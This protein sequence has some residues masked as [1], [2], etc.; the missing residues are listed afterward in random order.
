MNVLILVDIQNDFVPGG[1]L[2][3]EGGDQVVAVANELM[4]KFDLVIATQDWHPADH[5]S[6]ASQHE[7]RNVG[8]VID[9]DGLDQILWP[10]HCVQGTFGAEFVETLN[11]DG[12]DHVFTKGTQRQIDSY[13]GFFD[14]GRRHATGLGDFLKD[15]S[16]QLVSIMGLATDYCVKFTALDAA[17]LGFE[18][19]LIVAGCRG[20]ELKP[21]DIEAAI[22]EMSQAGVILE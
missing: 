7:G 6:F 3:V 8:D 19:R 10:D 1:A 22:E 5:L 17:S 9:L 14:N 16:V 13:S 18:T 15:E 12:I 4:P 21:G 20:V 11:R 2:A